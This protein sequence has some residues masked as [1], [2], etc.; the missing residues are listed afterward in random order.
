LTGAGR[1]RSAAQL[2]SL[3]AQVGV[4]RHDHLV[5]EAPQPAQ[6]ARRLRRRLAV[7][8]LIGD[9]PAQAEGRRADRGHG[10]G[11]GVGPDP[12]REVGQRRR[13]AEAHVDHRL[14][15]GEEA[16]DPG[17]RE[18]QPVEPGQGARDPA[19]PAGPADRQ[20][21]VSRH[22]HRAADTQPQRRQRADQPRRG[23][24]QRGDVAEGHQ[25]AGRRW[26]AD[27]GA[28]RVEIVDRVD[29]VDQLG[30]GVAGGQ[31]FEGDRA[32]VRRSSERVVVVDHQS[33]V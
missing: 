30:V 4:Q 8:G 29:R 16:A 21:Q 26:I 20:A 24:R 22:D 28:D 1:A 19:P 7:V 2:D 18:R 5:D 13:G 15:G 25:A 27:G 9:R 12:G 11:R 33:S 10:R 6:V 14:G 31:A 3:D 17:D 23:H 32:R